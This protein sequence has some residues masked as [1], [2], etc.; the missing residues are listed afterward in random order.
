MVGGGGVGVIHDAGQI[1]WPQPQ[2]TR[3]WLQEGKTDV[4]NGFRCFWCSEA[5]LPVCGVSLAGSEAT[6]DLILIQIGIRSRDGFGNEA[7]KKYPN[8]DI[9]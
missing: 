2:G 1:L 3:D 6:H 4:G 5:A 7:V 8:C 9:N